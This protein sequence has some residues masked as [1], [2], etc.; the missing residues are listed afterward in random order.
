M[1]KSLQIR[2]VDALP[3]KEIIDISHSF[4]D[5]GDENDILFASLSEYT[6]EAWVELIQEWAKANNITSKISHDGVDEIKIIIYLQMGKKWSLLL[7]E[8][9]RYGFEKL[10]EKRTTSQISANSFTIL[11]KLK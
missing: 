10:F 4:I 9:F 5:E 2:I 6:A 7:S 11:I 3:E 8:L 1:P